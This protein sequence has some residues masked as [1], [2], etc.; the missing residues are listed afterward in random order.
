MKKLDSRKAQANRQRLLRA[1]ADAFQVAGLFG[2]PRC[3]HSGTGISLKQQTGF[4]ATP[5]SQR[6]TRAHYSEYGTNKSIKF[7]EDL[8]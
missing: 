6:K 1:L 8:D 7:G 3:L 4:N 5:L 2:L